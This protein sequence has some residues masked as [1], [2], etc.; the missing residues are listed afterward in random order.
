MGEEL[1]ILEFPTDI[2]TTITIM[3]YK[4]MRPHNFHQR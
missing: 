3:T 4:S 1:S 2:S